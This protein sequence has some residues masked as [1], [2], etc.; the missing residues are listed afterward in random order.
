MKNNTQ[1]LLQSLNKVIDEQFINY[2]G[3]LLRRLICGYEWNKKR[4][5]SF[6]DL[7]KDIDAA[8]LSIQNSIKKGEQ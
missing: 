6:I 3:C 5:T 8:M 1:P 2:R 7:D 4:Y